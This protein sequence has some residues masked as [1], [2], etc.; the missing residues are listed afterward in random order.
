[1]TLAQRLFESRAK[2]PRAEKQLEQLLARVEVPFQS[3]GWD[4]Y[5]GSVELH[6]VPV[7][8]RLSL[9]AQRAIHEAGFVKAYVNHA[10]KWETHYSF[11]PRDPFKES[12]GWRVSY[13]HKRG[14]DK[15]GILVEAVVDSWPKE[16][17]DTGYCVVVA[18]SPS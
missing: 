6:G 18:P 2:H 16:W 5:D 15:K 8:Y 9:E 1:M 3:L 7:D 10:D 13:P 14:D 17:F 12:K 4:Y 11:S